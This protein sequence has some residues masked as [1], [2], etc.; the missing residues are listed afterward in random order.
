LKHYRLHTHTC[1]KVGINAFLR[2]F[3]KLAAVFDQTIPFGGQQ[4]PAQDTSR[5]TGGSQ[6]APNA[7]AASEAVGSRTI[8][9]E[10]W[11][12][13]GYAT[14]ENALQSVLWAMSRG[15]LSSFLA[16]LSPETQRAYANRFEGM[17]ETEIATRLNED[18]GQL[19]ALRLDRKQ[20]SGDD[21]VTFVLYS[22]ERYNGTTKTR[23]E[24]VMT[25]KIVGGEWKLDERQ[26][27]GSDPSLPDAE[28]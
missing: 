13:V 12:F 9:R 5:A 19:P 28:R 16:G 1:G 3:G 14:P 21:A 2:G 8:P 10:S 6:D 17:T 4:Q 22:E 26:H 23:D 25:F 18:I 15:D 27:S 24:A 7:E 20:V 11:A